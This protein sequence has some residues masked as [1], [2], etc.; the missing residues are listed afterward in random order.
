MSARH[1]GPREA[2]QIDVPTAL[3]AA[4]LKNFNG[5]INLSTSFTG[6]GGDLIVTSGSVDQTGTYVFEVE[7][8]AVSATH[9]K[10]TNYWGVSD[11]NDTMFT[12]FNP[13][14]APQNVVATFYYADGSGRYVLP[15]HLDP[16]A[17]TMISSW[18]R[19]LTPAAM[20][21]RGTF[22][23]AVPSSRAPRAVAKK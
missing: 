8:Q 5:S 3:S 19:N 20:S 14:N 16:Q 9:S 21:F 7:P 6:K 12:L 10:F 17:S 13:T 1:L 18:N 2:T 15:V 23:R 11:G 22:R 4:G